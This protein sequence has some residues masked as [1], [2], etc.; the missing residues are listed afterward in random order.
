MTDT[1]PQTRQIVLHTYFDEMTR[2]QVAERVGLSV[3]TVRKRL[4]TFYDRAR[5]LLETPGALPKALA[6]VAPELGVG[7]EGAAAALLGA[8]SLVWE[9]VGIEDA[10]SR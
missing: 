6:T 5:H 8:P 10:V 3:P 7:V 2:Q 9:L 1:D 4:N